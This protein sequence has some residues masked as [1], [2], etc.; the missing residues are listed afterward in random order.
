MPE[1]L[2]IDEFL[3]FSCLRLN[4]CELLAASHRCYRTNCSNILQKQLLC[5]MGWIWY[6]H[7]TTVS[8]HLV[9]LVQTSSYTFFLTAH[10]CQKNC[11][12]PLLTN[13]IRHY[14]QINNS[15]NHSDATGLNDGQNQCN[16][17][18]CSG[19]CFPLQRW[20]QPQQCRP[21]RRCSNGKVRK[22]TA[23]VIW[24]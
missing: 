23:A 8:E 24:L 16:L 7:R 1:K 15:N 17:C 22:T 13:L 11:N 2:V 14:S 4:D 9:R 19:S 21:R 12:N 3:F 18:Y 20:K 10:H 6:N 5:E